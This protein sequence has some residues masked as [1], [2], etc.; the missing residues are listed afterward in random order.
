MEVYQPAL[1]DDGEH[2]ARNALPPVLIDA[3]RN[4]IGCRWNGYN[5]INR[6]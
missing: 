5:D 1:I 4:G 6:K 2:A 3:A